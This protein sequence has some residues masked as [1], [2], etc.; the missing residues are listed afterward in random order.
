MNW[1]IAFVFWTKDNKKP[2]VIKAGLEF[3]KAR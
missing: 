1:L 3:V 2:A